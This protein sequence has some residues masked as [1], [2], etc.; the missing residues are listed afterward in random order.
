[1]GGGEACFGV[2]GDPGDFSTYRKTGAIIWN[3]YQAVTHMEWL[4]TA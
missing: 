1:M 4:V 2:A 3:L